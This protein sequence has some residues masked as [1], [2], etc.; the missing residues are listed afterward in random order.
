V[1]IVQC[2]PVAAVFESPIPPNAVCIDIVVLYLS[3]APIN[4]LTDIAIFFL[5][6][7]TLWRMRLPKKQKIILLLTFGTGFFVTVISVIRTVYL[8]DTAITRVHATQPGA[9]P[10]GSHDLSCMFIT[11]HSS[12]SP[13]TGQR[14]VRCV[15]TFVVCH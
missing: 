6:M 7:H 13:L 1:N 12:L 10:P 8:V 4:I 11:T 3:S 9:Q 15:S 2:R 5:P 14:R